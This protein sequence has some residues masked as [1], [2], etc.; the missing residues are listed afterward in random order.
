MIIIL[1][2]LYLAG[3]QQSCCATADPVGGHDTQPGTETPDW[4]GLDERLVSFFVTEIFYRM[5]LIHVS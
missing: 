5:K 2:L 4:Q 3:I 1:Q